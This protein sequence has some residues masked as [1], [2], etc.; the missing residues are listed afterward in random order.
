MQTPAELSPWNGEHVLPDGQSALT[1]VRHTFRQV[2]EPWTVWH[3]PRQA[4][5]SFAH[6]SPATEA[7]EH[8]PP[9][10]ALS[11]PSALQ[12]PPSAQRCES[13]HAGLELK[14]LQSLRHTYVPRSRTQ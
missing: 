11:P 12:T 14:K 1:A 2:S 3:V 9:I 8:L 6:D 10:A 7:T 5:P 13:E 4:L